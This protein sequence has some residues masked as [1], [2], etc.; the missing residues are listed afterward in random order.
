[1]NGIQIQIIGALGS[2][3]TRV[4]QEIVDTLREKGLAVKWD[5]SPDYQ[6]ESE[7]RLTGVDRINALESVS[8]KSTIVVK[9]I[10][11][12]KDFNASLNY[13]VDNHMSK[14]GDK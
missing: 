13:R 14:K 7:A 3:K 11:V 10:E 6:N 5:V 9:E 2:G 1:M 12:K 8:D 4:A